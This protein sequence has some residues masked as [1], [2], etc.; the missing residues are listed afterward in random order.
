M[1]VNSNI[2]LQESIF[3]LSPTKH[4]FFF[5]NQSEGGKKREREKAE[6]LSTVKATE[7]Q[8][9]ACQGTRDPGDAGTGAYI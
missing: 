3:L 2:P 7:F 6:W 5:F 1:L 9:Q 8:G 4:F